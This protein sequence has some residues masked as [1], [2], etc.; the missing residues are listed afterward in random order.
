DQNAYEKLGASH[1]LVGFAASP[2]DC[3]LA[4]RGMKTMAVRLNALQESALVIARWLVERPEVELVLHPA[5]PSCPGHELWK[6]DFTGSS[7]LF[8]V[9]FKPQ[10]SK[11]QVLEFIDALRLFYVRH[12]I[13]NRFKP[14]VQAHQTAAVGWSLGRLQIVRH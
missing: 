5:L 12:Q 4:L 10:Y 8:S 14:C 9:V 7:G 2:D 3:S 11:E 13:F 1:Q 6:R